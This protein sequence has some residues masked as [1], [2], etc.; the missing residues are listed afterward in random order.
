MIRVWRLT[1]RRTA[2]FDGEGSR[3]YGGRWNH[4][5][6]PAVYTAAHLSL[7]VLEVLVHVT[8]VADLPAD[9]V[10]I[11]ADLPDDLL[12]E[13]AR[14]ED[15]PRDWRRIPAPAALADR[16]TAWLTAARTAVL[17]V[18]SAVVPPETVYIL[19]PAHPDFRRI[20]VGRAEPF[21]L[22][23]RLGHGRGAS[24]PAVSSGRQ[25]RRAGSAPWRRPG[26]TGRSWS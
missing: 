26:S 16:G 13:N 5:G 24:S 20:I 22:D 11:P 18:P 17:A 21:G 10:A 2:G 19:N 4:P 25:P 14:I 3:R 12:I 23:A 6:A 8:A 15:L 9:L 1:K 7:A